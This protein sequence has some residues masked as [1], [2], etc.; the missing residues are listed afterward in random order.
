MLGVRNSATPTPIPTTTTSTIT[1]PT[2]SE[3]STKEQAQLQSSSPVRLKG[4]EG[5]ETLELLNQKYEE[6]SGGMRFVT[7]VN[8][9]GKGE[10][11]NE[12]RMR[13][14]KMIRMSEKGDGDDWGKEKEEVVVEEREMKVAIGAVC[15]IA[16]DRVR[17]LGVLTEERAG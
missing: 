9:R 2:I 15:D 11:L 8:G 6:Q 7:F 14:M 17:K 3:L 13:T 10:I 1:T 4:E 16:E 5:T 12:L